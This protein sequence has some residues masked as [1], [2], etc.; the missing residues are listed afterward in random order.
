MRFFTP[1]INTVRLL[2]KA[3]ISDRLL[4]TIVLV[5]GTLLSTTTLQATPPLRLAMRGQIVTGS[6]HTLLLGTNGSLY[7]WGSNASGQLGD[8]TLASHL[9]PTIVSAAAGTRFIQLAAG[10][11]HSLALNFDGRIYSWGN[12]ATGQLGDGTTTTRTAPIIVMVPSGLRFTQ[13]SASESYSVALTTNGKLYAWGNNSSGQLGDGT[14]TSH[15][16]P[17]AV[18]LPVDVHITQVSAGATQCLALTDNGDIYA[19]G[20]NSNGQL[21][22]GTVINRL[23]PILVSNTTLPTGIKFTQVASG[24]SHSIALSSDGKPYAWGRN[25]NGQLGDST[26]SDRLVPTSVKIRTVLL[27]LGTRFVQVLAG[28]AHS[29]ALA[30]DGKLY[31]WGNGADGQLGDGTSTTRTT[32]VPLSFPSNAYFTQIAVASNQGL[33]LTADGVLYA[34]GKNSEGQLGDGTLTTQYSPVIVKNSFAATGYV[35]ASTGSVHSVALRADGLLYAWGSN[36]NG[37]LGNG[38]VTGSTSP[39]QVNR[40]GLTP[41][42]RFIQVAAGSSHSLALATD[43]LVYAWGQIYGGAL[44]TSTGTDNTLPTA[45]RITGLPAG[46]RFTQVAA[47]AYI[48]LALAAD[49]TL[50][51]WGNDGVGAVS[52]I[53]AAVNVSALPIGTRFIQIAVG[54]GHSLALAANGTLYA[55]GD[56][57]L[58]QLGDGTVITHRTPQPVKVSSLPT[59]THFRQFVAGGYHTLAQATDGTLYAWGYDGYGCLG[60]DAST[61]PRLPAPVVVSGLPAGAQFTSLGAGGYHCLVLTNGRL[62][63]WGRSNYGQRGD[64][65]FY[66][67]AVPVQES[68]ASSNWLDLGSGG[69]GNH[70]LAIGS[71]DAIYSA[72]NNNAGQ[73][74]DGTYLNSPVF[75]RNR[76]VLPIRQAANA[77]SALTVYPVPAHGNLYITNAS[78]SSML[79]INDAI[80][81]VVASANTSTTGAA[82]L[83]LMP[84][85][86]PGI[87][88]VRC[89]TSTQ[90]LVVE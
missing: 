8:G 48:S 23:T 43:G 12:N 3:L 74:G 65:T 45:V 20:S 64:N 4:N 41:G 85:L 17:V 62:Y 79:T 10:G 51:Q 24:G 14:L 63:A 35:Q 88:I 7:A 83:Q 78:P 84:S 30:A 37:T 42:T 73:L 81:R 21:G 25:D 34:W 57:S 50:Y 59:G 19:W 52:S 71:G 77:V 68:S 90:R 44:G 9:T 47:G 27:P 22:D 70:S 76:A 46:T 60:T 18:S 69:A 28:S 72:G 13:I 61:N 89:G 6:A 53:P 2:L 15:S 49:G 33:A 16:L 1:L 54:Q 32:R 26:T 82:M 55:W 31:A 66:Q 56:N 38:T 5:I 67:S 36:S 87:Y 11:A 39:V 40:G 29:T 80:G 75:T 58:G 86:A